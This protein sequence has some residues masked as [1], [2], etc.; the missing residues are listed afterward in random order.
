VDGVPC[1]R[2]AAAELRRRE[3]AAAVHLHLSFNNSQ[4]F[5]RMMDA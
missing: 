2:V 4:L 3:H 1:D 5:E